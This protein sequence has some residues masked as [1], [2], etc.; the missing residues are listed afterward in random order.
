EPDFPTPD[1][2]IA[3][4]MQALREGHT[5]YTAAAGTPA[6]RRAI[7]QKLAREN[8][9]TFAPEQIVVACGAKQIIYEALSASLNAG[10]EV[11]VPAPY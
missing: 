3:A 9:L 10:D 2:I 4:G 8:H 11:I 5:R 6:L 1:S 7:S